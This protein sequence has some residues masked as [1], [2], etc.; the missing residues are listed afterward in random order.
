MLSLQTIF[1][2]DAGSGPGVS[3]EINLEPV[4]EVGENWLIQATIN[5]TGQVSSGSTSTSS[6]H[7]EVDIQAPDFNQVIP[8]KAHFTLNDMKATNRE[9]LVSSFT[10]LP[11]LSV[12]EIFKIID[13]SKNFLFSFEL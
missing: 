3:G 8:V 12:E 7:R 6:P 10:D 2:V 1:S 11:D 5:Y 13:K 4:I 9:V